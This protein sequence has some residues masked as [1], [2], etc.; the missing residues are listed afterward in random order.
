MQKAHPIFATLAHSQNAAGANVNA[1]VAHG[2]QGIQPVLEGAGGDDV[3]VVLGGCVQIVVVVVQPGL[4]QA[5][6]LGL[7]EHP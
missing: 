3:G 6:G 4:A 7:V 5:G 1:G 2:L